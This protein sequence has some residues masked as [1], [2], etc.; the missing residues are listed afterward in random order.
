MDFRIRTRFAA[1][2]LA[3]ALLAACSGGGGGNSSPPVVVT[4]PPGNFTDPVTYSTAPNASLPGAAEITAVTH[5]QITLNGTA[6]AY[7]AT[8]G[9]MSALSLGDGTPEASFFY[10]AYTADGAAPATRPVTFFY[11]GG[12]GSATIW[13]HLGSFGPKRI[14]TGEPNMSGQP[15]FPL[16]DNAESMLDV[17]DLV[18]VDAV[19]VGFSQA[20]APFENASFWGVDA[21]AAVFRDFVIRYVNVNNRASSPKFLYGESYGGPRTAV[22]SDLLEA[23]GVHLAGIV[24]QSPALNYNANCGVLDTVISCSAYLPSYGATAA[25]FGFSTPPATV[26]QLPAFTGEVKSFVR[27]EYQPAIATYLANGT[28]PPEA[29]LTRVAGTTGLALAHWQ[30]NPNRGP[31]FYRTNLRPGTLYGGYDTRVTMPA[32]GGTQDPSSTIITPSFAQR[33]NEHVAN[34]LHYTTPSSYVMLSNAI[35]RWNFGHD[36]HAVPDTVPDLASAMTQNPRLKVLAVNG[37]HDIVT[38]FFVTEQDLERLGANPNI[39]IRNFVGGH[40]TY[41]ENSSRRAMKA[42]LVDFYR[43]ALEN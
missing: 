23:A 15:P 43:S 14:D 27:A 8:A 5:H 20:I 12:P 28:H 19:G 34:T 41:L 21:D 31:E 1:P 17:S 18:F 39:R 24:L 4:P 11:N 3:L 7:T 13:L 29:M 6:L 37:Y 38:P 35:Q 36:G 16:V 42:E 10:V 30:A 22:L 33:F 9:H 32:T 40:M 25:W 26:A 2:A